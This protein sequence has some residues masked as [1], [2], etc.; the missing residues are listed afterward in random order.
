MRHLFN[1]VD[2]KSLQHDSLNKFK[3]DLKFLET[4]KERKTAM[5]GIKP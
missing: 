4:N 2:N 1:H 3:D 5:E